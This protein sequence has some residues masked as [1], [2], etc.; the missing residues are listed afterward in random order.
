M[1]LFKYLTV[2]SI[3]FAPCYAQAQ[4]L[5]SPQDPGVEDMSQ[6]RLETSK[7]P[8]GYIAEGVLD[9]TANSDYTGP[10]RGRLSRPIYSIDGR[11]ILFPVGSVVVGNVYRVEGPNEAINNRLGFAPSHLVK[12]DGQAFEI[13][14]Q[15]ILDKTGINAIKDQV[16]YHL[17]E[18]FAA[19]GA[20]TVINVLPEVLV[21]RLKKDGNQNADNIQNFS[22]DLTE[23]GASILEK[24]T[25]LVPTEIIRAG[26]PFRVFFTK[27]LFTKPWKRVRP[28]NLASGG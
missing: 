12:P 8:I 26:T 18:Q 24:Y 19:T 25:E 28:Y 13:G 14:D 27:E 11:D 17:Y 16:D 7:I 20:Y 3:G 9:T 23:R 22:G 2:L 21:D 1:K 10:W 4:S 5:L 6:S 15:E